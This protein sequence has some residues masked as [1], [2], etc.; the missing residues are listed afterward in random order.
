MLCTGATGQTDR[1]DRM[2]GTD[3]RKDSGDTICPSIE[4]G[5]GIKTLLHNLKVGGLFCNII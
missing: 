2:D 3:V 5:G 1:T 4:N